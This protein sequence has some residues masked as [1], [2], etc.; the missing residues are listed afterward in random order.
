MYLEN[1]LGEVALAERIPKQATKVW[2]GGRQEAL[3]NNE[4]H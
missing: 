1:Q 4:S 3:R 2:L